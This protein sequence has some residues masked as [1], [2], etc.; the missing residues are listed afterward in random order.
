MNF[1]VFIISSLLLL[2]LVTTTG[3]QLVA[4]GGN[5]MKKKCLDNERDALLLFKAS[6]QDPYDYLSTWRADEHDCCKWSGVTCSNQT[7][8]VT[9]LDINVYW[10][11]G[12]I[13]HSLLNLTYLNHLGLYGN[14][15]YGTIPTFIGSLTR[16]RYLNLGLNHF[17]G[18]IPRSIGSLTELSY[19]SLSYNSLYGTIPPELETSPTCKSFI[20]ILLEGVEWKR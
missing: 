8:H 10:L 7:G 19:L 20:L 1:C 5:D 3:S 2:L 11:E 14:A 9:G 13:S 18:T 15:F 17:N 4:A 16:L 12:E 6:F